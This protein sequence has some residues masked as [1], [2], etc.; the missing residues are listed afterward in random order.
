VADEE[1]KLTAKISIEIDPASQ[2]KVVADAKKI[3]H[4]AAEVVTDEMRT[5]AS[6]IGAELQKTEGRDREITR[7]AKRSR[8]VGYDPGVPKQ[9]GASQARQILYNLGSTTNASRINAY[10]QYQERVMTRAEALE[11][12]RVETIRANSRLQTDL[13]SVRLL[14]NVLEQRQPG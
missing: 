1:K 5:R 13:Y 14:A 11:R 4:A 2:A 6:A 9:S 3:G 12:S 8:A 7:R 10:P